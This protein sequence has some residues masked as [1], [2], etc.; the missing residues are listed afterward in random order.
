MKHHP[1]NILFAG[2]VYTA[3][4]KDAPCPLPGREDYVVATS[5][6]GIPAYWIDGILYMRNH[7]A[8]T[9]DFDNAEV[10]G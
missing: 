5:H 2:H 9:R 3:R 6:R 4:I 7:D 8:T 10:V 1:T